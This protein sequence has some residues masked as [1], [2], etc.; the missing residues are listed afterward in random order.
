MSENEEPQ[1]WACR[2]CFHYHRAADHPHIPEQGTC[3]ADKDY[4]V[5]ATHCCPKFLSRVGLK[6]LPKR[7]KPLGPAFIRQQVYQAQLDSAKAT[8]NP[9][10]DYPKLKPLEEPTGSEASRDRIFA[11]AAA[12][13]AKGFIPFLQR[14]AGEGAPLNN[15]EGGCGLFSGGEWLSDG[16]KLLPLSETEVGVI[17]RMRKAKHE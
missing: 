4:P 11:E 15:L 16:E 5:W 14:P 10:G 2:A 6:G 13:F 17:Q 3:W 1:D 7:V 9:V 12:R 8:G